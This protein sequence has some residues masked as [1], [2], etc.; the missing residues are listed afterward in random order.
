MANRTKC[1]GRRCAAAGA[2]RC[3]CV[4][5]AALLAGCGNSAE[6]DAP[7][8]AAPQSVCAS[9]GASLAAGLTGA[10]EGGGLGAC[11]GAEPQEEGVSGC[12]S[13]VSPPLSGAPGSCAGFPPKLGSGPAWAVHGVSRCELRRQLAAVSACYPPAR[14]S[15]DMLRQVFNY[16]RS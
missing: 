9:G 10:P 1:S 2:D 13:G 12:V 8:A 16:F 11:S 4:A 3:V 5:L 14:P 6:A 7:A 15:S